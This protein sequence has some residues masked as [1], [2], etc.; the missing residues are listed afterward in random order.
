MRSE[1]VQAAYKDAQEKRIAA[2]TKK[3]YG[4]T[5]GKDGKVSKLGFFASQQGQVTAASVNEGIRT[6]R[7]NY[8]TAI[9]DLG[10]AEIT[11]DGLEAARENVGVTQLVVQKR[12]AAKR[13]PT[14]ARLTTAG[15]M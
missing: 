12:E 9:D 5:V 4:D 8:A 3:G 2:K 13:S 14:G 11:G 10:V 1:K 6:A 7:F 15:S